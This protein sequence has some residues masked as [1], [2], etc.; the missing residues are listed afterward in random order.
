[1]VEHV[2]TD[3]RAALPGHSLDEADSKACELSSVSTCFS[4][5]EHTDESAFTILWAR[6]E[7]TQRSWHTIPVSFVI[8]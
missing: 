3:A 7:D 2:F 6:G 4:L 1:M 5:P 8:N